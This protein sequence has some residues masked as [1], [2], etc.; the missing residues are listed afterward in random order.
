MDLRLTAKVPATDGE[1]AAVDDVL[2]PPSSQWEGGERHAR[3]AHAARGGHAARDRGHLL[4]TVL[5]ALQDKA[6]WISPGALDYVSTRLTVPPATAYGVASFYAMFRTEPSPGAV[7]HVCDDVACQVGGAEAL[8]A[9]M[10]RRFG[11]EGTEAVLDGTGVS[12][13]RS[14]CLGKCDR[15][16]AALIQQP[17]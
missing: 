11:P 15:G 7:V 1:R 9:E 2:G 5:H 6:G 16:S 3:D 17:G 10:E 4:I 14:P 13:Q 8:C 12:W